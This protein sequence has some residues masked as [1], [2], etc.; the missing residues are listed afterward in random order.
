MGTTSSHYVFPLYHLYQLVK[1]LALY[2]INISKSF[3]SRNKP[4]V[5]F[6]ILSNWD[7]TP[8]IRNYFIGTTFFNV[9]KRIAGLGFDVAS[10]AIGLNLSW[11]RNIYF[12]YIWPQ[13]KTCHSRNR[14]SWMDTLI[15]Q[16]ALEEEVTDTTLSSNF[17]YSYLL[18]PPQATAIP[19]VHILFGVSLSIGITA[20]P[21]THCIV[22][23]S[24]I[25]S[26]LCSFTI[27]QQKSFVNSFPHFYLILSNIYR[28]IWTIDFYSPID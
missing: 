4:A 3:P 12:L 27:L 1:D 18:S 23:C 14:I 21:N 10:Y 20:F 25:L 22:S 15:W 2:K 17:P 13:V 11:F 6:A 8:Y 28:S 5:I 7:K 19:P 9:L 26:S 16:T 24:C